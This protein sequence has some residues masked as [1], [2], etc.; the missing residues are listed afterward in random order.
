MP[1]GQRRT[2]LR[3]SIAAEPHSVETHGP[4]PSQGN[5]WSNS[6]R[7][8]YLYAR[9]RLYAYHRIPR[10]NDRIFRTLNLD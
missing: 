9:I 3:L 4:C 7:A 8:V 2:Q 6:S 10:N 1:I 5:H